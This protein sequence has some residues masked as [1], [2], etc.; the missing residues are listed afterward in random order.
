[1]SNNKRDHLAQRVLGESIFFFNLS[2]M[3][4]LI[5]YFSTKGISDEEIQQKM[6][7][8]NMHTQDPS[9]SKFSFLLFLNDTLGEAM[10]DAL[11]KDDPMLVK[12][13]EQE[14]TKQT[15]RKLYPVLSAGNPA[16]ELEGVCIKKRTTAKELQIMA[17]LESQLAKIELKDIIFIDMLGDNN[18]NLNLIPNFEEYSINVAKKFL[19][20]ETK[21]FD[22][23]QLDEFIKKK[24]IH[25]GRYIVDL[26]INRQRIITL[27]FINWE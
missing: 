11:I 26:S 16:L 21:I 2:T 22:S 15:L 24:N 7:I 5:N 25:L 23:D 18:Y 10:F 8:F 1:M 4:K 14:Y 17:K 3:Q 6:E 19:M 12:N 27:R 9:R 20:F 13:A